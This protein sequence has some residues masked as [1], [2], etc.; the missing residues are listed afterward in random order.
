MTDHLKSQLL[1]LSFDKPQNF[2]QKNALKMI[3][4]RQIGIGAAF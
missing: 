3:K 2:K 1:H 4:N